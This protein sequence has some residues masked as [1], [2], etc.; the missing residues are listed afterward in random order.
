MKKTYKNK[1]PKDMEVESTNIRVENGELIVE[2]EFEDKYVP[3]FGDIVRVDLLEDDADF[4]ECQY[5]V[6]IYPDKKFSECNDF[7]DIATLTRGKDIEYI[8][9]SF[10]KSIS[11]ATESEEQELFDKLA[12]AGKRWN[13]EKKCLEDIKPVIR[14]YQDLINNNIGIKGYFN[15][16]VHEISSDQL[17]IV[18]YSP[19]ID[20]EQIRIQAAIAAMQGVFASKQIDPYRDDVVKMA[21]IYADALIEE[22]KKKKK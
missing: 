21:V 14:T 18:D 19:Y 2:I 13:A 12:K 11:K 7:F 10:V 4:E 5:M 9:G 6:S 22:L 8:A 20:W 3:K 15:G 17:Q 16:T 1:L